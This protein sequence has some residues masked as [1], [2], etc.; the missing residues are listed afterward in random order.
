MMM[1]WMPD[2]EISPPHHPACVV[3]EHPLEKFM[4]EPVSDDAI[5]IDH[6]ARVGF[7]RMF[8]DNWTSLVPGSIER[9]LWLEIAAKMLKEARRWHKA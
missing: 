8:E 9:A 2:Y 5:V 4:T 1:G 6:M 3:C 7:E